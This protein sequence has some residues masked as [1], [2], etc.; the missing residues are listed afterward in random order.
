M[1]QVLAFLFLNHLK[2]ILIVSKVN[3]NV[4][5]PVEDSDVGGP[6]FAGNVMMSN[7]GISSLC[8]KSQ[9]TT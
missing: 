3:I 8:S 6:I 2:G 7:D 4:V 9:A 1:K 5:M